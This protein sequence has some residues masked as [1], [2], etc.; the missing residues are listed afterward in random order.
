MTFRVAFNATPLLAPLTGIGNYTIQ[1]GEAL[2]GTG[3]VDPF[4]FYGFRWRHE[5]PAAA[6]NARAARS[7]PRLRDAIK[8]FVPFKRELRLLQQ[9]TAFAR[10]LRRHAIALY[11]EPNYVPI[12]YDV[13]VVITVHDLSW[14]RYPETHPKERIRWLTQRM[15]TA[16]ERAAAVLTDSEFVRREL[17]ATFTVA[18]DRIHTAQLGVSANFRP[19]SEAET[20]PTLRALDLEH[21]RYLLTV[22][23]IEPRKNVAHVLA[24]YALLPQALRD[25]YPLV[26]AGAKGWRAPDLERQLRGLASSGSIRFLGRV[27]DERLPS[28][29]AGA[30][31][32][33]FPSLY[34]GFGLP[35]LEAMAS[36]VPVLVSDRASLPEIAGGA[37]IML[38]PEDPA[39]TAASIAAIL[40]DPAARARYARLARERAAAFSWAA[41]AQATLRVYRG[42]PGLRA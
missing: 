38:D 16:L 12:A 6:F 30:A 14:I 10:G 13:P 36:G 20:L 29:Y 39:T 22:G 1:L 23:T 3:E 19:R 15:P 11:H 18:P 41:C 17:L 25:E 42:V 7:A 21:R 4:S 8:P 26:V 37:A 24:A 33:V 40:E 2:A 31:A 28:L 5:A 35:P 9:R 32:F 34:E 27:A